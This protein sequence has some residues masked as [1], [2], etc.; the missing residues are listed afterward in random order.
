MREMTPEQF[1]QLKQ[2][3]DLQIQ[4]AKAH[5]EASVQMFQIVVGATLLPLLTT[6]LGYL[7]GRRAT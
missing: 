2:T 5:N 6:L 1:N 4:I 7:L 3:A